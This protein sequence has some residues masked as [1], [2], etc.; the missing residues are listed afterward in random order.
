VHRPRTIPE[1]YAAALLLLR[2]G[3]RGIVDV[4]RRQQK[5]R[6]RARSFGSKTDRSIRVRRT[7]LLRP[8]LVVVKPNIRALGPRLLRPT[9]VV[10]PLALSRIAWRSFGVAAIQRR[11]SRRRRRDGRA[12]RWRRSITIF[13]RPS[14]A[15]V[16]GEKLIKN[17]HVVQIKLV[18]A[19]QRERIIVDIRTLL[20]HHHH[21]HQQQQQ[22]QPVA[23]DEIRLLKVRSSRA[24]E[25]SRRVFR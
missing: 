25:R 22:Q 3:I 16:V 19:R 20:H 2:L 10:K 24:G 6:F 4:T 14:Q 7:R 23:E 21:R 17:R 9:V 18:D 11:P 12:Q 5:I 8:A 1:A 13:V 15:K